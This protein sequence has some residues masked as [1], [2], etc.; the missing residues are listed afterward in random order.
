MKERR[1]YR[2]R[3]CIA[4]AAFVLSVASATTSVTA[5]N[6]LPHKV[7]AATAAVRAKHH[8]KLFIA[9]LDG[10]QYI[11]Y[12]PV[13]IQRV[14]RALQERGLYTGPMNGILDWETMKSIYAFQEANKLQRC[15]VPTPHTR[16]M[17]EQGSHTDLG[18]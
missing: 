7:I 12:H 17:L 1:P 2:S 13:T 6:E 5:Q 4:V 16:K 15:G 14:Q 11:P 10:A 8:H 18:F 9:G 3:T